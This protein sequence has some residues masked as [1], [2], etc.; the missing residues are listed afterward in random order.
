MT[1]VLICPSDLTGASQPDHRD[2]YTPIAQFFQKSDIWR[3]SSSVLDDITGLSYNNIQF[4]QLIEIL[5]QKGWLG[6]SCSYARSQSDIALGIVGYF[7]LK[8]PNASLDFTAI[9]NIHH[10][11]AALPTSDCKPLRY[12][13]RS[14]DDA[15]FFD[16]EEVLTFPG[17]NGY[18]RYSYTSS[19][20]TWANNWVLS[21]D[22]ID[23]QELW[24]FWKKEASMNQQFAS[25][26]GQHSLQLVSN[27]DYE[28]KA[29]LTK[30]ECRNADSEGDIPKKIPV[31]IF[32]KISQWKFHPDT[33]LPI[34]IATA[35]ASF[36]PVPPW[37]ND[38]EWP[39]INETNGVYKLI[40]R[41]DSHYGFA[42]YQIPRCSL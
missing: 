14:Y 39:W 9:G 1:I 13:F 38:E 34:I 36:D 42:Y 32:E 16:P 27:Y 20:R 12:R 26:L 29:Q 37:I 24:R 23:V 19:G 22:N 5:T 11:I 7:T 21:Y 10:A 35:R 18:I 25:H 2:A 33:G 31:Y 40:N 28:W 15:S 6:Y 4:S 41:R 17:E 8:K 3:N 30:D